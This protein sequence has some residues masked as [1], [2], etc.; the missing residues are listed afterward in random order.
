[1]LASVLYIALRR[2]LQLVALAC[3]SEEFKELEIVCSVMGSRSCGARSRGPRFGPPTA[4]SWPPRA[5]SSRASAGVRPSSRPTRSCAGIASSWRGAGPTQHRAGRPPIGGEIRE[6]VLRL[7]RENRR[8]GYQ[9]IAGELRAL[10]FSVA[11]TTI[12]K[13]PREARLGPAGQRAGVSWRECIRGQAAS[14]LACDFFTVDTVLAT[15][16]Y[17]LFSSS[18][19]AAGSTS[20][21]A[22]SIPTTPGSRSRRASSRGRS[23]TEPRPHAS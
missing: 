14:M 22:P 2:L 20:R 17:V 21:A 4:R 1:L 5:G 15:R 9:R 10:G 12:R 3:R 23:P 7:A 8:W 19:G 6:L 18:S 13:L 11:T 16:L